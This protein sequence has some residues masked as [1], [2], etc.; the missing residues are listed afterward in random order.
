MKN[1]KKWYL[2]KSL[3]RIKD[4]LKKVAQENFTEKGEKRRN[5]NL[6]EK[7]KQKVVEYRRNYITHNK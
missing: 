5:K 2:S 6:Y 7:Q 4:R 1:I 3:W